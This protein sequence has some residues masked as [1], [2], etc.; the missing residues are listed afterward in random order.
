MIMTEIITI[1]TRQF[2]KTSSDTF[3][4]RQIETGKI[5]QEAMDIIPCP[6]TY[7]ESG[8]LLPE[9]ELTDSEALSI[10]LG[11]GAE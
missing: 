7:E 11:G 1:G 9:L 8:E 3:M 6:Y 2:Q 10:I 4:I 5:Y